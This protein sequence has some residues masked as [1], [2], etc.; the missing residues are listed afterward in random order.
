MR[1]AKCRRSADTNWFVFLEESYDEIEVLLR[2]DPFGT[3]GLSE[4]D[5]PLE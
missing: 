1:N 3:Y 4:S 2:G 5:S